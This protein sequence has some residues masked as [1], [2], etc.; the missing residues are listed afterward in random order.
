MNINLTKSSLLAAQEIIRD[1]TIK[2]HKDLNYLE[3]HKTTLDIS[4]GKKII[5]TLGSDIIS[6]FNQAP[7]DS[8]RQLILR[9]ILMSFI[10]KAKPG[11]MFRITG[12]RTYFLD[13]VSENFEQ[14]LKEA[15]LL[16]KIDLSEEGQ[17]I[18]NWWDEVSEFVRKLD[19]VEKLDLGR[20]GEKKT[21]IYEENKLKTLNIDKKPSW[22]SYEDNF[23]GYDI[24]SWD[25][26]INKIF[27]EVKAASHPSGLFFLTRNEWNFSI[28]V[29]DSFFIH[30]WIQ[31]QKK[32]RIIS[33]RELNSKNY[34]IED[35]SNAA[36]SDIK[37]TPIKIN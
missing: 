6:E 3:S 15:G 30:V 23:L 24:Q 26:D 32:P 13:Y 20:E 27:I 1:K 21:M 4:N 34:K 17:K 18:S 8:N 11:F 36:W 31:D 5:D 7:K 25:K 2:Q 35:A 37:I 12:G 10:K 16:D 9:K 33:F 29:K 28:S 14:L 19:K 22:D